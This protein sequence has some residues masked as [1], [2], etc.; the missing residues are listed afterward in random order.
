MVVRDSCVGFILL[1]FCGVSLMWE[2]NSLFFPSAFV[3]PNDGCTDSNA[4]VAFRKA[5]KVTR[6]RILSDFSHD[7]VQFILFIKFIFHTVK[8]EKETSWHQRLN[9]NTSIRKQTRLSVGLSVCL[10]FLFVFLCFSFCCCWCCPPFT[11]FCLCCVALRCVA[12]ICL[13][14][15]TISFSFWLIYVIYFQFWSFCG[16]I[17]FL[18]GFIFWK[19][20]FFFVLLLAY[21]GLFSN[22]LYATH[23]QNQKWQRKKSNI[24][25]L[26]IVT[27]VQD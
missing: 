20:S 4:T 5:I 11:G 1:L 7:F 22:Y 6:K 25:R 18:L 26:I 3:F 8:T 21:C 23:T 13:V 9:N 2:R 24:E 12:W 16:F 17:G 10:H 14:L 27:Y 19:F 15:F